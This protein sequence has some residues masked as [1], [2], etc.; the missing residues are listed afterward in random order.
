MI[1]QGTPDRV[2][3]AAGIDHGKI[4]AHDEVAV[5]QR[6]GVL[7]DLQPAKQP[8]EVSGPRQVVIVFQR[9]QPQAFAKPARAQEQQ[10]FAGLLDQRN[11]VGAIHV[12][13]AF[14]KDR[15][16]IGNAVG[17]THGH[18]TGFL[19]ENEAFS[20]SLATRRGGAERRGGSTAH[21]PPEIKVILLVPALHSVGP[22]RRSSGNFRLRFRR[23]F[24]FRSRFRRGRFL[25][26]LSF[27]LLLHIPF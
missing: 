23:R 25:R 3:I 5:V 14:I 10:L 19:A 2:Q 8:L 11:P 27:F 4:P 18:F 21:R 20:P 7:A 12:E 17:K 6:R 16:K 15:L 22:S 26:R 13:I 1:K 24:R 9:G